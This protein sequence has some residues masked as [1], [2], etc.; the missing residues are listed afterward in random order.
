[1]AVNTD[2]IVQ[3]ASDVAVVGLSAYAA[4]QAMHG[5]KKKKKKKKRLHSFFE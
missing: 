3:A 4:S 2:K 5:F 1:M